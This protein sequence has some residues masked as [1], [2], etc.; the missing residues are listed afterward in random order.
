MGD[1][2]N[3]KLIAGVIV[4]LSLLASGFAESKPPEPE[5]MEF[6]QEIEGV[7]LPPYAKWYT[8]LVTAKGHATPI[9]GWFDTDPRLAEM[10]RKT[11]W[12]HYQSDSQ[13]FRHQLAAAYGNDF[14]MLVIQ[15]HDGAMRAQLTGTLLKQIQTPDELIGALD[16]A[17]QTLRPVELRK[18][19]EAVVGGWIFNRRPRPSPNV[20]PGPNCN[21][22]LPPAPNEDDY[23]QPPA[24]TKPKETPPAKSSTP[25][26]DLAISIFGDRAKPWVNGFNPA[27]T[28]IAGGIVGGA[29]WWK[30]R[31]NR[32]ASKS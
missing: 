32:K 14:P 17:A 9:A 6:V 3:R 31:K 2:M 8:V 4:G 18:A 7:E 10:K 27:E 26:A 12:R 13:A 5:Q 16:L 22:D 25:W 1:M 15:D 23:N 24:E 11:E 21:P 28:L 30:R 29:L 20:C 19:R